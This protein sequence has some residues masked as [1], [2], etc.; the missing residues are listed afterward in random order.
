MNQAAAC[1]VLLYAF[2]LVALTP[3]RRR[4]LEGPHMGAVRAILGLPK[5]SP[6]AATL[7]EAGEWP[8]TLRMLQRALGHI[9]RL[10]H[11]TDGRA[12]LERFRGQPG[13]RMGGLSLLYDQMV[14]NPPIQVAPSTA[15]R[16]ATRGPPLL[17]WG[18]QATNTCGRTAA[19]SHLQ[20]PGA[21]GGAAAGVHRRIRHARWD[22]SG[23]MCH[24]VQGQQQAVQAALPGELHGCGA[25]WSSPGGGPVGR[26]HPS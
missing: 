9:D 25:G 23:C 26:G 4:L 19:G 6:V 8:L 12:L 14:P 17:G 22:H 3:A 13:S 10:H 1:S 18:N 20:A 11:A 24:P 21:T 5:C 2:S 16:P 7:A 15:T